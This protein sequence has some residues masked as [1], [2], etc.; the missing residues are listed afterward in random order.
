MLEL[1]RNQQLINL[2][3]ELNTQEQLYNKGVD[4]TGKELADIG[5][6]YP[7]G[8]GY[9]PATIEGTHNFKGKL[10]KGQPIDRVTLKDTGDFY[11]SWRVFLDS[12]SDLEI[13]NDPIKGSTDL[14][15]E[16]GKNVI[17]LTDESQSKFNDR[18]KEILPNIILNILQTSIAA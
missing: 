16:W 17:G 1:S 13:T 18:V 11:R 2:I 5:G 10:A 9:S 12:N 6:R 3:I 15:K 8:L 14:L 7:S 4:S